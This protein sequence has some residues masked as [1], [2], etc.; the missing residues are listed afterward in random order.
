MAHRYAR[1][2]LALLLGAF[3]AVG[4]A[5]SANA[6]TTPTVAEV[7]SGLGNSPVYNQAG[8]EEA[9][10]SSQ[11]SDL[12]SQIN[13]AGTPIYISVVSQEFVNQNGGTATKA[14]V[15]IHDQLGLS[16]TYAIVG[17]KSFRA[18]STLF[19]VSGIANTAFADNKSQG[20]YAVLTSFVT[21]VS[22]YVSSG[23]NTG[24]GSGTGTGPGIDSGTG[25]SSSGASGFVILGI[26]LVAL[27]AAAGLGFWAYRKNKVV[28]AQRLA[29]VGATVGEDVTD[30]GN[31]LEGIDL[32]DPKLGADGEADLS[33]A[34][35]SYSSA[36]TMLD[37]MKSSAEAGQATQA[38]EDG[39]F[40]LACVD[41]RLGGVP[42]PERR[43]PCFF[44]PRHGPSVKDENW[45]PPGGAARPV[46]VCAAC[47]TTLA[48]GYQPETRQVL[49]AGGQTV[50]YYQ[51]GPAYASYG[52]GYFDSFGS[53]LPWLFVASAFN[54]PN[55]VYINNAGG[56]D[57]GG[58]GG[59][60]GG[61]GGGGD[62]GGGGGWGGGDFGG[63][64][65]DGGG[66]F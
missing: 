14:L 24:T 21:G 5:P 48:S 47:A 23:G 32:H 40:Y 41:A 39:R 46:P 7:A 62:F 22:D 16:G 54:Q 2:S 50:P 38:L 63:G 34:L 42:L 17:G 58:G 35:D 29:L 44:D 56:Q 27:F 11:V 13:G 36:R 33:R 53:V 15:A 28:Q 66:S 12:A 65:G 64:G 26:L 25:T 20:V 10:T 60:F 18:K 43:P 57:S 4:F 9:L 37:N 59:L 51:G 3:I 30:L 49:T 19:D 31:K 52:R 6:A 61:G 8:A 1:A 55:N 45:A